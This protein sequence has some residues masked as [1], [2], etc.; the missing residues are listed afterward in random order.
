MNSITKG[1]KV[2]HKSYGIFHIL[3]RKFEGEVEGMG[4]RGRGR[5]RKMESESKSTQE[6]RNL[7]INA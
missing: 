5:E 7:T 3:K 4:V 2:E 6:K 1:E